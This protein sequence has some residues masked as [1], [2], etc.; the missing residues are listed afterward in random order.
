MPAG[1][2]VVAV[3]IAGALIVLSVMGSMSGTVNPLAVYAM[4][5]LGALAAWAWVRAIR[6]LGPVGVLVTIVVLGA[7][8]VWLTVARGESL[9]RRRE[10]MGLCTRCGYD[11]RASP[12]MCPE[13]G[14]EVHEEQK[15]RRRV[16]AE[17]AAARAQRDARAMMDPSTA[18][19]TSAADRQGG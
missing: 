17:V 12:D 13:C 14:A 9:R 10:T 18:S 6:A 1:V 16:A 5:A 3:V 8:T 19:D 4:L 15:R 11:L 7:W 2:L